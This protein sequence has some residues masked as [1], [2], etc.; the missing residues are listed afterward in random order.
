MGKLWQSI[1]WLSLAQLE[2]NNCDHIEPRPIARINPKTNHRAGRTHAHFAASLCHVRRTRSPIKPA[3]V[4]LKMHSFHS[5]AA[6]E[7]A[8]TILQIVCSRIAVQSR[9]DVERQN[10]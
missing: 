6:T 9:Q 10:S 1:E 7:C 8:G 2:P 3:Q 5:T 4:I